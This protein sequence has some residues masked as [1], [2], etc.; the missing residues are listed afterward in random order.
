MHCKVARK[1]PKSSSKPVSRQPNALQKQPEG[2]PEAAPK[3]FQGRLGVHSK[4]ARR[5][6]ESSSKAVPSPLE[7]VAKVVRAVGKVGPR[8]SCAGTLRVYYV[9]VQGFKL[10]FCLVVSISLI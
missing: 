8:R 2:R 10:C 1:L 6:P 7:C 9:C 4:V 3:L 5:P